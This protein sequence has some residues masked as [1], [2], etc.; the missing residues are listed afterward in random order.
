MEKIKKLRKLFKQYNLDGYIVPKNNN[1]FGEYVPAV[2]DNLKYISNF[3]GSAGFAVILKN[4]NFLFVDGRYTTQASIQS[5]KSY[6]IFTIPKKYPF[7]VINDKN[8][9]LGFDPR[10]HT[11]NSL[12][13]LFNKSL[14]KLKPINKNLIDLLWKRK[15]NLNIKP[16][17][18]IKDLN[19][20]E[21]FDNKISKLCKIIKSNKVDY[22]FTTASENIAWLL[23]IR[24]QDTD[25]SPLPNAHA[26]IGKNKELVLFC[27]LK[28]ITKILK[29]K[30]NKKIKIYD[31]NELP[32]FISNLIN[33]KIL[34]DV[35]SCSIYFKT[36]INKNNSIVEKQDPIYFLKSLKNK[37]EIRNSI[38]SHIYDGAALTKF[39]FWLKN[40]F[41]KKKITEISAQEKLLEFR[42]KNKSFYSLSFPTISGAGPNASIIHYKADKES[43]R[44]LK[45]GDVY[46]VD[47]G[48]QY[49]YG[50]TDVT[51]TLSL[52][53]RN[54]KIKEIFTRVLKGHIAVVSHKLNRDTNG[55]QIDRA[56]RKPLREINLDYPHGTGHGVGYFLNVHEG[57]QGISRGNKVRFEEG[58]I[59]SN[60]PGF[61]QKNQFGIRIENLIYVKKIK[62]KLKFVDLTLAPIDKSLV[63]K[64]LLTS[65]EK[66]WLNTYHQRVF[67]NLK[68]FMNKFELIQ[69]K[70]AC[71]NI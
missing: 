60:E 68:Q 49:L 33:K 37:I 66:Y 11:E 35:L 55:D 17:Y 23:N 3:T 56:A 32:S 62:N 47:S 50:T 20:G 70:Q 64:K 38:K 57:P 40:S 1:F 54:P 29:S 13:R 2:E 52:D 15:K 8:I 71:S 10:L 28:K 59:T 7:D 53:V 19:A 67:K 34:I 63:I 26:F 46:L 25:Y 42:K 9:N 41:K 14:V 61:Y 4:R 36:L 31:F 24:G 69:L 44:L 58:M 65:S 39:I 45:K 30:L 48:G 5:G 51:R 18:L 43:N 16:F 27:N 21:K 22:L 12:I 6:K